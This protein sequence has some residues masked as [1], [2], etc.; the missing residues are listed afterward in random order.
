MAK[1]KFPTQNITNTLCFFGSGLSTIVEGQRLG[2]VHI[3]EGTCSRLC[4][5]LRNMNTDI[6]IYKYMYIFKYTKIYMCV[7]IYTCACTYAW[8][9]TCV[10]VFFVV[11]C[12]VMSCAA[13]CSLLVV[14]WV[15]GWLGMVWC[16]VLL[17]TCRCRGGP[18]PW[19]FLLRMMSI[20]QRARAERSMIVELDS[21]WNMLS[22]PFSKLCAWC[23]DTRRRFECTHGDVLSGHT[24]HHT[25][26]P[27]TTTRPQHHTE[28]ETE[29]EDREKRQ[30]QRVKRRRKRRRQDQR[31]EK[32]HFQCGGA[33]PFFV[34]GV[35][36]LV[37]PVCARDFCLL[38]KVKYDC[39][40]I[41]FS[42]S[43]QVTSFF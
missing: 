22:S 28:T 38:I 30:R 42:A 2:T 3:M 7:Y 25:P 11:W 27:T 40:L 43:W 12:R 39:S 31:R 23:R 33:W 14:G 19:S 4:F 24:T 18:C 5:Y 10:S 34:D 32:I 36:F 29:K 20:L 16:R 15:V 17:S 1:S 21:T 37:T 8:A 9:C 35:L 41:S 26:Q 13:R 6:Y